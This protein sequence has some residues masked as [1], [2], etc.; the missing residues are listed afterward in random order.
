MN[1][2]W[3]YDVKAE[4]YTG[5]YKF[6]TKAFAI[7]SFQETVNQAGTD[8]NKHPEDYTLFETGTCDERTASIVDHKAKI[9]LGTA[10]DYLNQEQERPALRAVEDSK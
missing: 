1:I 7:R 9:P 3:I 4:A 6:P 5:P 10:L 8:F 2:Y